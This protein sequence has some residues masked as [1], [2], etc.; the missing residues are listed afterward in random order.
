MKASNS[1]GVSEDRLITKKQAAERLAVS[2][3]TI[4]RMS[5][6]GRLE[7][8]FVGPSPRFRKSDIDRIV[9]Q[10]TLWMLTAR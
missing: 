3:R 10:G 1:S 8:I 5:A 9:D 2:T 7:K 4:D 6:N